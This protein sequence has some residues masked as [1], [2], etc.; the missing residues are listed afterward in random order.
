MRKVCLLI[1]LSVLLVFCTGCSNLIFGKKM[2]SPDK[3]ETDID[4]STLEAKISEL[5]T[6]TD[7]LNT[8]ISVLENKLDNVQEKL[9]T[10]SAAPTGG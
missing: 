1:A 2:P 7:N 8:K 3:A 6:I 5:E 10:T 4:I 9:Q